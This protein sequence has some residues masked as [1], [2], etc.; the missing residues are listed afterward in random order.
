MVGWARKSRAIE[1]CRFALKE[2][3]RL[4]KKP[5]DQ[6]ERLPKSRSDPHLSMRQLYEGQLGSNKGAFTT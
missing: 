3:T 4:S 1:D 6:H 2:L 5:E